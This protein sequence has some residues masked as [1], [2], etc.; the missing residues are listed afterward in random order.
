MVKAKIE[1][2]G[3]SYEIHVAVFEQLQED[4]LLGI[5]L[6]LEKHLIYTIN[7]EKKQTAREQL[8][9]SETSYAVTTRAQAQK[10]TTQKET[11]STNR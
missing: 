3:H 4:A 8:G 9:P 11:Q 5:D 10:Q 7:S 2:D 6:P 1:L